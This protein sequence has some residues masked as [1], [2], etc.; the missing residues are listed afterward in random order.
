LKNLIPGGFGSYKGIVL[1]VLA[2]L[3][4]WLVTG[5]FRVQPNQQAI[6]LV[7]G[8]PYGKPVEPGLHYNLPSP[9]GNVVVVNVQDQRRVVI[10]LVLDHD[11]DTNVDEALREAMLRESRRA[12]IFETLLTKYSLSSGEEFSWVP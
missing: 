8:K 2:G 4:I 6:Q 11:K 3:V 10:I 7:F 5:F 9:I 1:V 12:P